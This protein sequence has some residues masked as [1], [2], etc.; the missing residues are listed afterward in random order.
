VD[1]ERVAVRLRISCEDPDTTEE[2]AGDLLQWQGVWEDPAGA[3]S[4]DPAVW[5]FV[6]QE[7]V[8]LSG[9]LVAYV[10]LRATSK[11]KP[12]TVECGQNLH[13][14]VKPGITEEEMAALVQLLAK[15][16]ELRAK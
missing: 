13:I 9:P 7:L 12:I 16:G 15:C 3:H 2:V 6:V 1:P 10:A 14:I 11:G 4:M 8:A 5:E